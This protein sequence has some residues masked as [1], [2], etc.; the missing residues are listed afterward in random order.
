[1]LA[2]I[3]ST[4]VSRVPVVSFGQKLMQI[5]SKN[6]K[7]F[8][9]DIHR[10]AFGNYPARFELALSPW[11][12]APVLACLIPATAGM[13]APLQVLER[14]GT[15]NAWFEKV[16]CLAFSPDA[17]NLAAGSGASPLQVND[18]QESPAFLPEGTIELWALE[19]GKL[20]STLRQSGQTKTG[21]LANWMR[22]LTFSPNGKWLIGS[23]QLGYTLWELAAG[24]TKFKWH[25]SFISDCFS[26]AWSPDGRWIS[27]PV[28]DQPDAPD[29]TSPRHGIG[30]VEAATE[31]SAMFFPVEIG[32]ARTA[33][34]SPDGKLLATAG[35][36]GTVRVFE[37]GTMTNVF[38]DF[39]QTTL[40]A[41]GFTPDGRS[42]VAG[43]SWGGALLIY[44][45]QSQDG[46]TVIRKKG[47]STSSGREIH[48]IEFTLD[49]KCALSNSPAGLELWRLP[50][51]TMFKTLNKCYGRL[52][53]DGRRV[54]LVREAAPSRIEI[55]ALEELE[56]DAPD[57]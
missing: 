42:L 40:Y 16:A 52:S 24:K 32:Y 45:V 31:K 36:D 27:L 5:A 14:P 11:L 30:V 6:C 47:K 21:G 7:F 13:A 1:M 38:S 23:D 3:F 50:A 18:P 57:K 22:D 10:L 12:L 29:P 35:H 44:E 49:G 28:I 48:S 56:K 19:T 20:V 4:S 43:S 53:P 15:H 26:P 37:L 46:K 9:R 54:A 55:W 8:G 17:K 51:W 41:V 2:V 33:R 25:P 39:V 34:I